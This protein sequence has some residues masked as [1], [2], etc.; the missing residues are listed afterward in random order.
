MTM[1]TKETRR[2][3]EAFFASVTT[4]AAPDLLAQHFSVDADW[5][6]LGPSQ[7]PWAGAR[8]GRQAVA[9]FYTELRQ[10]CVPLHYEVLKLVVEGDL[11]FAAGLFSLSLRNGGRVIEG[12]FALE[13]TVVHDLIT[14][15]RFYEDT[16]AVAATVRRAG[17]EP[18]FS[19]P[20]A[21]YDPVRHGYSQLAT[22][23]EPAKITAVAGQF[24]VD[25]NGAPVQGFD[26][27][28]DR[29]LENVETALKA[30]GQT[31]A[32]V[33]RLTV[34]IVDL[35]DERLAVFEAAVKR[36][37]VKGPPTTLIPVSRLAAPCVSIEID[38]LAAG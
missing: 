11:A 7:I 16:F 9:Q 31:L 10:H 17:I 22:M 19:N 34:L 25:V 28:V 21:L 1:A 37:F 32:N 24:G 15:Y 20:P 26:R 29:A 23:S 35:D 8:R 3:M 5:E 4:G 36:R 13:T 27:E 6:V 18:A 12:R 2:A 30:A 38:A 14:Q 33:A